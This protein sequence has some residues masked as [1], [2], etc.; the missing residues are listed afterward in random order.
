MK[1]MAAE[2]RLVIHMGG[3]STGDLGRPANGLRNWAIRGKIA[4]ERRGVDGEQM[5]AF[6]ETP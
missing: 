6:S 1:S 3:A 4:K 5:A 2:N